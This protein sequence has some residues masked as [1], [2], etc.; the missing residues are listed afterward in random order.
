MDRLPALASPESISLVVV[1]ANRK[2][3]AELLS[4]TADLPVCLRSA[5]E[6]P[7]LPPVKETGLT[8]AENAA[9]KA[10]SASRATGLLALADDS[11]LEVDALG[12]AP[13]VHSARYAATGQGNATDAANRA[14]L[15]EALR[16]VPPVRRAARFRCALAVAREGNVVLRAEGSVEGTI[17]SEER[18]SGG[19]GYDP[20]FL[21]AG[22]A[23]TFAEM[24]A[25]E[26]ARFSHRAR[27]IE[28]LKPRLRELLASF[29]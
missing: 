2:K 12:G 24:E 5:L 18:G 4:L 11:G 9:L 16:G 29:E 28:A 10:V 3:L 19:F 20:L 15:L 1:S 7:D 13:G 14:K 25:E 27:A 23:R 17:L 6:F 8:F 22:S 21:P 26:K